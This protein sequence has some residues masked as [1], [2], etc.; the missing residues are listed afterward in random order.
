MSDKGIKLNI[1]A[2][3]T[4]KQVKDLVKYINP[5]VETYISIFAGRIADTGRDPIPIM[6]SSVRLVK[7]TKSKI[8]WAS[9]REIYNIFQANDSGCHIITVGYEFIKK[10]NLIGYNL[11]N[12][13]LDTVRTFF[14]DAKKSG[15]KIK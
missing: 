10:L 15:Y 9:T 6:K 3:M 5:N 2:I 12:Y 1:T 4:F 13:S 14:T 8:L 11:E 7:K